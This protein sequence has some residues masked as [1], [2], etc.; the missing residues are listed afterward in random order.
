MNVL[1]LTVGSTLNYALRIFHALL[2]NTVNVNSLYF[3]NYKG[4]DKNIIDK[5]VNFN[6]D[7]IAISLLTY[8]FKAVKEL[9]TFFRRYLP[10]EKTKI[11]LGGPHTFLDPMECLTVGDFICNGEGEITLLNLC[12]SFLNSKKWEAVDLDCITNLGYLFNGKLK[13]SRFQDFY[14]TRN[15][16]IDDIPFPAYGEAGIHSYIDG[17]WKG[18][19]FID[20][21]YY[22]TFSSRGCPNRCT[23][24][25]NS[26][27]SNRKV[28]FRNPKK[29]IDEL[30]IIK[31]K[32]NNIRH[33]AFLDEIFCWRLDWTQEFVELYSKYVGLP[34]ECD[35]FPGRHSETTISLLAKAGLKKVNVGVQSCSKR[36]LKEIY[37]RPQK[38]EDIICDNK[39]YISK[40][41]LPTYDFIVDNPF[42]TYDDMLETIEVVRKISRPVFF[43]IYSL[44]FFPYFPITLRAKRQG[45]CDPIEYNKYYYDKI[46]TNHRGDQYCNKSWFKQ[47]RKV[48]TQRDQK[49]GLNWIL[50]CYG[51]PYIPK[52]AV[53][54]AFKYLKDGNYNVVLVLAYYYRIIDNIFKFLRRLSASKR[55]II[56]YGLVEF[57]IK[58]IR[59]CRTRSMEARTP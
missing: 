55:Y 42:E 23:Y 34:F 59:M 10:S 25:I 24:C 9:I 21:D 51:D 20:F 16:I 12:E 46:T 5:I 49:A 7:L 13:W 11:I 39:Y 22:Q 48:K 33:I 14:Y 58:L 44:F 1:N 41:I 8:E 53:D 26:C 6:P 32:F 36:I 4:P 45:V 31:N 27:Y 35:S 2:S 29:V 37:N 54:Q 18:D 30:I 38:S 17:S 19:I 43:R 40:D 47:P 50:T 28:V 52:F 57:M 3:S 15:N 56:N